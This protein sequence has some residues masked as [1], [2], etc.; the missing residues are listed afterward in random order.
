MNTTLETKV[1]IETHGCKLNQA[2]SG[3][4]ALQFIEAGFK[5]VEIG[6]PTD[7]Y[8]VN[9]CTVTHIADRKAR[10]SLRSARRQNPKATIVA[11]GCYVDRDAKALSAIPEID[12]IAN[13]ANKATL[14]SEIIASQGDGFVSC[15]LGTDQIPINLNTI[16]TRASIKIQEGCD[17]VCAY[18]IVP[19]VRGR[20]RSIPANEIV[21]NINKLETIGYKEIVLTGTQ[22][23]TYGFDITG[24]PNKLHLLI[25]H[26]LENTTLARLR[27][28]SIQPQ[29]INSELLR[30]WENPRVCP[31]MHI[32]LQSGSNRILKLMRRRYTRD[33]YLSSVEI[34]MSK[35]SEFSIT[36]DIIVGFPE[37]SGQDYEDTVDVVNRVGFS[38]LHVFPFSVR[39]GTTAA[40]LTDQIASSVKSVRVNE[41]IRLGDEKS[42]AHQKQLIGKIRPV[43]WEGRKNRKWIGLTD[44]YVRVCLSDE[45]D[46]YNTISRVLIEEES[47]GY[48][49]CLLAE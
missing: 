12:I 17:Q 5:L 41:L 11:T 1:S 16:K 40:H 13:N 46:L 7:I 34:V 9:T 2:D 20:E 48:L 23:G 32:P 47:N 27:V 42:R 43:L 37:E 15:T 22:L 38:K 26:I 18:C 24:G 45:R 36:T 33:E 28:S 3:K 4:L 31:H 30:V 39:P 25:E 29:E 49:N 19:K 21:A 8:I 35:F 10:R 6:Q 44:T 14:V